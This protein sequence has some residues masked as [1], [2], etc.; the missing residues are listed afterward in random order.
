MLWEGRSL[1][2]LPLFGERGNNMNDKDRSEFVRQYMAEEFSA[3]KMEGNKG[4]LQR[5]VKLFRTLI[6]HRMENL[7][8]PK[9]REPYYMIGKGGT[10]PAGGMGG[11]FG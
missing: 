10:G 11:P 4:G 9:E 2:V 8:S 6:R 7:F 1:C 5:Y 3:W